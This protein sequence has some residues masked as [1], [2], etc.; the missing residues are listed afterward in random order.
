M[1]TAKWRRQSNGAGGANGARRKQSNMHLL[2]EN[3]PAQQT[4][5]RD[6]RVEHELESNDSLGSGESSIFAVARHT[7]FVWCRLCRDDFV[8]VCCRDAN[9]R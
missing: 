8:K 2:G 6:A 9:A 4:I 1:H 5:S 7:A 3:A